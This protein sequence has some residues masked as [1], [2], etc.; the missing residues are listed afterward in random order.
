MLPDKVKVVNFDYA[1]LDFRVSMI[2]RLL[3]AL[4]PPLCFES[5]FTRTFPGN[6]DVAVK[7]KFEVIYV[8]FW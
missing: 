7:Q 4:D 2:G 3:G 6:Q 5:G 8:K 1:S